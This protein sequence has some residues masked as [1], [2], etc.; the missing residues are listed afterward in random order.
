MVNLNLPARVRAEQAAHERELNRLAAKEA[1]AAEDAE[2]D[3]KI[4]ARVVR[5]VGPKTAKKKTGRGGR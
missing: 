4:A 1:Q 5:D 3:E 2:L